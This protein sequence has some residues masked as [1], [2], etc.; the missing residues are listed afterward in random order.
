M[1]QMKYALSFLLGMVTCYYIA[2]P[3]PMVEVDALT[4]QQIAFE[5]VELLEANHFDT[6]ETLRLIAEPK[7]SWFSFN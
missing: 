3:T 1:L 2:P 6:L 5:V 4:K 7:K